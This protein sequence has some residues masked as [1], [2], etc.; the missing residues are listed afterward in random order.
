VS[1]ASLI[2]QDPFGPIQSDTAAVHGVHGTPG[3]RI[4]ASATKPG[5][6]LIFK[7]APEAAKSNGA[8]D[9]SPASLEGVG[10][11]ETVE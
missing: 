6:S 10:G 1:A 5:D 8:A 4:R 7:W 3:L 2:S 9:K 11:I